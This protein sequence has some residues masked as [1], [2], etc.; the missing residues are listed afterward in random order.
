[1]SEVCRFG[2]VVIKMHPDDHMPAHFHIQQR[3]RKA[4]MEIGTLE[5]VKGKLSPA[6]L[7]QIRRWARAR[8][9]ELD[10]AWRQVRANQHPDRIAPLD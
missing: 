8:E 6:T 2:S 1:M 10:R 9:R 4:K 3:G 5:L 7:R